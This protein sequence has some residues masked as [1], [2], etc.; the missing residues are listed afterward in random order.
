MSA[1]TATRPAT[2]SRRTSL[3]GTPPLAAARA[4]PS[5]TLARATSTT[6][7]R[8]ASLSTSVSARK[9]A[10]PIKSPI[11]ETNG[12]HVDELPPNMGNETLML[13][14]RRETEEKEELL[15]KLQNKEQQITTMQEE[16]DNLSGALNAAESRLSEVYGDQER[17]ESEMEGQ[18]K[19]IEKLRA[20]VRETEK[21]KREVQ[22]RYNE[23]TTS[24]DAERQSFY[25]NENHLKSRIQ[26]LSQARKKAMQEPPSP[27][28]RAVSI[29]P[30]T[31]IEEEEETPE[32]PVQEAT[33]ERDDNDEPPEMMALRLELDT[34]TVSHTSLQATTQL[35]QAQLHDLQRVNNSLQEE[36]ESYNILLRERTLTGQ[37]DATR[38]AGTS[39]AS[40]APSTADD[41]DD[42]SIRSGT[43]SLLDRVPEVD[44][45]LADTMSPANVKQ[46][47]EGHGAVSPRSSR[48][49]P[50]RRGTGSPPPRGENLGDLPIT[51]PGLDLASELGRA[52]NKDILD[53]RPP[54]DE[55]FSRKGKS[56]EPN[57]DVAALRSEV[58]ALKDAN[59]AL[60]LYASK[61]LDR[62]ISEEGFEHILAVDYTGEPSKDTPA[63]AR[64]NSTAATPSATPQKQPA[65]A[66]PTSQGFFSRAPPVELDRIATSNAVA[67]P[68]AGPTTAPADT[69][70][71]R[72]S[73][74]FD[75]KGFFGGDKKA[76]GP[77]SDAS[78]ANLRQL[79]LRPGA[80]STVI[81]SARK[82]ETHEDDDDRRERER[83]NA[84]MKL[85]GIDPPPMSPLTPRP[86]TSSM[87]MM[88]SMSTSTSGA[89][90]FP[91]PRSPGPATAT[92]SRF[93]FFRSRSNTTN[94]S[95]NNSS[96]NVRINQQPLTSEALERVE[97]EQTI[98]QLDLRE[99]EMS[100]E[101]GKG[102]GSGF[103]EVPPR[104]SLGDEWRSRR[105]RKSG[106]DSNSGSTVFSAGKT[107]ADSIRM[108][109]DDL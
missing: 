54:A 43:R 98:A 3:S 53:G 68:V 88:S 105:S 71:N 83:L 32:A 66:R 36:N 77:P 2:T 101:L 49:R 103:T 76:P 84:T 24:F 51:G 23:Q 44:E 62:I 70:R 47:D 67:P 38:F 12:F 69:K 1:A 50:G 82:L 5:P 27:S 52:E 102:K 61:I 74:S 10:P 95:S 35:L 11:K 42:R 41:D 33:S 21:E 60:S 59:K 9:A 48:P 7:P 58:K 107:D 31:D 93:S 28:I 108:P 29:A 90:A 85:M 87:S 45:T 55:K 13:S 37:F 39:S 18:I 4:T 64:K 34:L 56:D 91:E 26:S 78:S 72:R 92:P 86:P 40:G 73:L 17:M 80:N 100:V 79:T 104:G 8:L 94:N 96:E 75:F 97:A 109:D 63:S 14:L 16:S 30:E 6:R 20:Q 19:L 15:V 65:K 57:A 106:K 25:D 46:D 81:G 22:R 99:K 89:S